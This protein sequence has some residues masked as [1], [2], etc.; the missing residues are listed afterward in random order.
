M[1]H[2]IFPIA[3][4]G[5]RTR[6]RGAFKPFIKVAGRRVIEWC[7]LGLK[8]HIKRGDTFTFIT[9]QAH[10]ETH[11]VEA[12]LDTLIDCHYG[13]FF[14]CVE[15]TPSGQAH[16]VLA[17]RDVGLDPTTPAV[18]VNVDQ[19]V[20]FDMP[21]L[22]DDECFMAIH[23]NVHGGSC[24]VHVDDGK[25]KDIAEKRLISSCASSGVFGFGT[26]R[27]MFD[28][29]EWGVQSSFHHA[30]EH[31]IGPCMMY[32]VMN[33]SVYPAYTY[34]KLDLGTID[35]IERFENCPLFSWDCGRLD[36]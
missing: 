34:L 13:H 22:Q 2:W 19:Y 20:T 29:L 1:T 8:R 32:G 11:D 31:Y 7:L 3:G 27:L 28:S 12:V 26:T 21:T 17:C 33:G 9:T 24:Y 16:T 25:I 15:K 35:G 18:I 5:S 23:T 10:A 36:G 4:D 14:V 30:N 6:A